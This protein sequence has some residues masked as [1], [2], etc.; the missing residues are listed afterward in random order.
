M[1]QFLAFAL[2]KP[3]LTPCPAFRGMSSE[4][5]AGALVLLQDR[6]EPINH[7]DQGAPD[8]DVEGIYID[9]HQ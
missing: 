6:L 3:W 8:P 7:S 9:D 4:R 1:A 2:D 5:A